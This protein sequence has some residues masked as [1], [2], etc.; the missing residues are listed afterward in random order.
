M[1]RINDEGLERFT[2]LSL[3]GD[4]RLAQAGDEFLPHGILA[5]QPLL[6]DLDLVRNREKRGFAD[7]V[8]PFDETRG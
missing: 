1:D 2:N 4:A 8:Y 5:I 7:L 3:R 6:G